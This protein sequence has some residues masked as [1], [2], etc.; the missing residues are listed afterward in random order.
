[1]QCFCGPAPFVHIARSVTVLLAQRFVFPCASQRASM[2]SFEPSG[3][4]DGGVDVL[5]LPP[6]YRQVD[7]R[8]LILFPLESSISPVTAP[9]GGGPP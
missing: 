1:M 9:D 8:S 7:P 2:T 6:M 3:F 5:P 4:L